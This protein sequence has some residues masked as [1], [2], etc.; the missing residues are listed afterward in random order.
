MSGRPDN[1]ARRKE[2][3]DDPTIAIGGSIAILDSQSPETIRYFKNQICSALDTLIIIDEKN[4]HRQR[5]F[6]NPKRDNQGEGN[7]P[8]S[9]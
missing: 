6:T 9:E 4:K 5:Q 3:N 2:I 1:N 7:S 8:L